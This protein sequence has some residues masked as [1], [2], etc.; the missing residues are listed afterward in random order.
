[1]KKDFDPRKSVAYKARM[2]WEELVA[3]KK[4][5]L[6]RRL[7]IGEIILEALRNRV[8]FLNRSKG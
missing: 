6:E 2:P 8:T 1:M 4:E 7:T 5:A 3:L